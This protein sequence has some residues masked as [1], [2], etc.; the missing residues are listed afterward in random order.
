MLCGVAV[1]HQHFSV[2]CCLQS[3]PNIG[4]ALQH[5]R[6]SQPRR[7]QPESSLLWKPQIPLHTIFLGW[8][9][10]SPPKLRMQEYLEEHAFI[11]KGKHWGCGRTWVIHSILICSCTHYVRAISTKSHITVPIWH[12]YYIR[13]TWKQMLLHYC[14]CTSVYPS[15]QTESIMKYTL[16]KIQTHWEATQRIMATKLTILTHKIVIKLQLV[17]ENCTI[18]SSHSKWPVWKLLDTS[19]YMPE[20]S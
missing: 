5:Y 14:K 3:H 13:K 8:L 7:T 20:I 12:W 15:F 1:G 9:I 4:T 2:P 11:S 17:A 18:C 19:S 6:A 16:T 10:S